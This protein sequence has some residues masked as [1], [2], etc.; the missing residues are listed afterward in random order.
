[1]SV[2]LTPIEDFDLNGVTVNATEPLPAMGPLAQTVIHLVGTAP[3]K[4]GVE[5]NEPIRL[6]NYS[7]AMVTLDSVGTR[8]GTLPYVV[9][10]LLQYVKCVL[11]VTIVEQ[12][13]DNAATESNVIGGVD[14]TTG[15]YTGL[16]TIKQCPET[17]TVIGAPGFS[18]TALGQELALMGRDVRAVPVIDG[19]NTTNQAAAEFAAEFGSEGT[20][21]DKLCIIDPWFLKTYDDAQQL[22]PASIAL[23]AAMANIE[24]YESPQNQTVVCDDTSRPISYKINDD[25]TEANFLNKY[26]VVTIAHTRMGGYSIIGNRA[27]TGRFIAHV[28][29]EDLLARKLEE[30]SQP[31]MGKLITQQF[32]TNVVDRLNNWGQDLVANGVIPLFK[33]FLH[34]SKNTVDAYTSG[35]WY[36]CFNYGRYSPNEHMIYEM[37]AD[38]GLVETWWENIVDE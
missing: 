7:D 25:T 18:S 13:E 12:G 9:R 10:Y 34:P 8:E 21:E 24:G 23:I 37:S 38:N 1:M 6:Y 11:Y 29:L 35:K 31:L 26:G 19:P 36:L 22:M 3:N 16:Q 27:N 20:G 17:P 5:Y 32:V 4:T 28:G 15:A 2:T 14:S 30:T 33:V